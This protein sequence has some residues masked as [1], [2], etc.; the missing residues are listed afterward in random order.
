MSYEHPY[1]SPELPSVPE[2]HGYHVTDDP[3][4]VLDALCNGVPLDRGQDTT[5][6]GDL[7]ASGLYFSEYPKL[8]M[9]RASH[10]WHFTKSLSE[11]QRVS[12]SQAILQDSKF[13]GGWYLTHSEKERAARW[14]ER[15]TESGEAVYLQFLANQPYN[16]ASWK[17]EFLE[18]FEAVNSRPPQVISVQT[19]GVFANITSAHISAELV[20]GLKQSGYDGA[21]VV[22][23]IAFLDQSVVWNNSAV[24]RFGEYRAEDVE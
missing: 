20:T 8:W 16:F 23:S 1:R 15:F 21:F 10:K 18:Q 14:L 5:T 24:V 3:Q 17:P 22:G 6:H 4:Q 13:S 19:R 12:I 9:G 11:H 7:L 2:L